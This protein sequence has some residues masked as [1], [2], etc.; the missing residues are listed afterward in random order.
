MD[1]PIHNP[2]LSGWRRTG[3]GATAGVCVVVGDVIG[4]GFMWISS[5]WGRI[6][7]RV[8]GHGSAAGQSTE[9]VIRY[10]GWLL[11]FFLQ[12]LHFCR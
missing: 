1:G 11:A 12:C 9:E 6:Q 7:A 4:S 10:N 8:S 5:V 2:G 3:G